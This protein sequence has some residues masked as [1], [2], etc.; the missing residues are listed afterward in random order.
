MTESLLKRCVPAKPSAGSRAR[1]IDGQP[2][3]DYRDVRTSQLVSTAVAADLLG[4]TV[5]GLEGMRM[6]RTGPPFVR[7]SG[8][9][10]RYSLGDLE[11]FVATKLVRTEV[12]V[13]VATY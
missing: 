13:E 1:N 11:R 9:C 4:L 2:H 3:E 8:R 5:R 6:R 7:I 10:I 12:T